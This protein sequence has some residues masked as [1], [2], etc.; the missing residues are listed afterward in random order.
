MIS[1]EKVKQ[2]P[3]GFPNPKF[4]VI[5]VIRNKKNLHC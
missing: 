2:F 1:F 3:I 4:I 5:P